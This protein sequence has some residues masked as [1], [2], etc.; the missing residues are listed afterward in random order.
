MHYKILQLRN[1]TGYRFMNYD[2]AKLHGFDFADYTLEYEG[3]IDLLPNESINEV[4]ER[5]LIKF[6]IDR[7]DNFRG[8]SIS[9]SDLIDLDGT[10]C[11]CNSTGWECEI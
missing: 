2:F 9:V 4:L 8:H 3:D 6:N 1:D 10:C 11:Y 5:L 7:P